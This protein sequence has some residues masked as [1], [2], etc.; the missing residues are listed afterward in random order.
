MDVVRRCKTNM[1]CYTQKHIPV[2][3]ANSFKDP[4]EQR[5]VLH[6]GKCVQSWGRGSGPGW[7]PL[8]SQPT[9]SRARARRQG[10]AAPMAALQVSQASEQMMDAGP[11]K[12]CTGLPASAV[13]VMHR[14][15]CFVLICGSVLR[16]REDSEGVLIKYF[17]CNT[18]W[19][20]RSCP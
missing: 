20:S 2:V 17:H 6:C 11:C 9:T 4:N 14:S 8:T 15:D 3:K 10:P 1:I 12:G 7:G 18:E 13:T 5:S 19:K 16:L